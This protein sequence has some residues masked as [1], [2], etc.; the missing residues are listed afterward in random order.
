MN[1]R[2]PAKVKLI[3]KKIEFESRPPRADYGMKYMSWMEV[4]I[5]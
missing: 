4:I 5:T 3:I 1:I 2:A